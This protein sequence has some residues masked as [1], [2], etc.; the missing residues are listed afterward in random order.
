VRIPEAWK[1]FADPDLE[2]GVGVLKRKS[3]IFGF[4]CENRRFL[5]FLGGES[6]VRIPELWKR[7]LD[8][9]SGNGV[10][11]LNFTVSSPL[12]HIWPTTYNDRRNFF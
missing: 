2:N 3:S 5:D 8:P 4:L 11:V 1:C 12:G 10:G 7:F 9:D 6:I